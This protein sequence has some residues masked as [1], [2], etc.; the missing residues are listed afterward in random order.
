MVTFVFT[1][2]SEKRF[3]SLSGKVRKRILDKLKN[4]KNHDDVF[5][6]LKRLHHLEPATHRLRIGDYR[7]ILEISDRKGECVKFLILDVGDRRD[8]YK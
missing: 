5:A 2:K 6:V 8:I 1:K 4:L 3:L 7:L